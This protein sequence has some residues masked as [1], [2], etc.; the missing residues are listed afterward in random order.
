MLNYFGTG[1]L[2][3]TINAIFFVQLIL[4]PFMIIFKNWKQLIKKF[5]KRNLEI[6]LVGKGKKIFNQKQ[7]NEMYEKE[8]WTIYSKYVFVLKNFALAVFYAPIMPI[9]ILY[10]IILLGIYFWAQ[11][12]YLIKSCNKK[13]KYGSYISLKLNQELGLC[14]ILYVVSPKIIRLDLALKKI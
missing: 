14:L 13:I 5:K 12:L 1:G 3:E 6:F 8:D 4:I 11:K 2:I 7:A 9:F 10:A